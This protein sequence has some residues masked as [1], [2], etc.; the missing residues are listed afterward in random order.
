MMVERA[1]FGS[2]A[3]ILKAAYAGKRWKAIRNDK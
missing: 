1:E 3:S 2:Y